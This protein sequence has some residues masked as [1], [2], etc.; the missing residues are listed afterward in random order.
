M[1]QRDYEEQ[2]EAPDLGEMVQED[3][4]ETLVGPSDS[5]PLDAGYV[6]PDRPYLVEDD[7]A[8]SS[9]PEGLDGRLARERPDVGEPGA[10]PDT[11]LDRAPRFE[12]DQDARGRDT[13]ATQATDVGLAGGAASAEEAA[14]REEDELEGSRRR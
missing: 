4:A 1:S 12:A 2:P 9:E 3:P 11:Q 13:G 8:M 14:V 5:D 7:A 6:P 10:T